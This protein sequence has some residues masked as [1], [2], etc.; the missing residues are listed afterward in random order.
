MP[1]RTHLAALAL[2]L[3]SGYAEAGGFA[4]NGR[5]LG[6]GIDSVLNDPRYECGGVSACL[7][8]TV[9]TLKVPGSE[10]LVDAPLEGLSLHFGGER[11]TA[12]EA[13]FRSDRF[14]EVLND[15]IH[16]LGPGHAEL[17]NLRAEPQGAVGNSVYVWREGS[18]LLRLERTSRDPAR[19]S[20][21]ITQKSFLSELLGR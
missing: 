13:Q 11:L 4:L 17:G 15:L 3:C 20:L 7:L 21:I 8:Y 6:S 16:E 5:E 1:L 10:T 14:D 12:I 2:C 18:Q 19:S 9:C